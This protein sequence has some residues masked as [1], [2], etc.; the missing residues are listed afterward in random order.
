MEKGF[1]LY[2]VCDSK[3]TDTGCTLKDTDQFISCD[4][5]TIIA[6]SINIPTEKLEDDVLLSWAKN[7]HQS[8]E[9]FQQYYQNILPFSFM[10]IVKGDED[11]VRQW[12]K[13][14]HNRLVQNIEKIRNK[15]EYCIQITCAMEG[16]IAHVVSHSSELQL[17][18]AKSECELKGAS[19]LYKKQYKEKEN[20]AIKQYTKQ[21]FQKY[22]A[23]IKKYV[24]DTYIEKVKSLDDDLLMIMNLSVLADVIQVNRLGALLDDIQDEG[25]DI[26]FTG[27]VPPYSFTER[28]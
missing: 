18:K 23:T 22:F 21:L 8:L 24:S 3:V 4:G 5:L 7:H 20:Q 2:C 11:K 27:P 14:N 13:D 1:Y 6:Q 17:L 12:I 28:F 16:L 26:Q 15:L 25:F 19:Y 9:R 10:T